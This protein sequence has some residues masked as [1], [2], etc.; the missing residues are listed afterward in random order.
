[1]QFKTVQLKDGSEIVIDLDAKR[2]RCRQCKVSICWG[3]TKNHQNI[4]LT[5]FLPNRFRAHFDDCTG[6]T[7][8]SNLEKNIDREENLNSA[9]NNF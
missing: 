9:L 2:K 1:M 7:R 4:P 8:K 5:E 3:V 6:E